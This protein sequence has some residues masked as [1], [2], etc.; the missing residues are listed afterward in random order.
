MSITLISL[1]AIGGLV[2]GAPDAGWHKNAFFGL[3]YDLHPNE[4]DTELGRETT[5]EGIR[6][7]LEKV[8]PDFVQY[9][10]KGH[11]GWA[12]YPTKVGS[13][14]PGIVNDALKVW[15]KVT[16]DMGIPLSIHYSGVWDTR[17]IQLHSEWAR[18]AEDGKPDPNNTDPLSDYTEKLMIPQL[19]EVIENYD[20]DG[21]W[22]DGENWASAPCYSD[23]C[24]AEFTKRTSTAEI[25]MKKGD[26]HWDE[27]LAFQRDLFTEHV[28]K[29]TT[30]LHAKSGSPRK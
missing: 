25:P 30:A 8:K 29:V 7:E 22:I 23:R 10:C 6:A 18:I 28:T 4:K 13:P 26:P 1:V 3:H 20:I 19:L 14:S 2:T 24:K 17:A 27:W 16:K 15:R 21:V 12:G 5:Y 9:D 11:P